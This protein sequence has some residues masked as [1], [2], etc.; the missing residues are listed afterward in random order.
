MLRFKSVPFVFGEEEYI[1][2]EPTAGQMAE[3]VK[4]Q[5]AGDTTRAALLTAM[6]CLLDKSG[7]KVFL[8]TGIEQMMV[9]EGLSM[10]AIM[11]IT[12]VAMR[13]VNPADNE[14]K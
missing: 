5:E 13:L 2:R 7:A 12:R 4:T 11:E 3:I 1:I 8:N 9:D 10:N 6:Y 14:K